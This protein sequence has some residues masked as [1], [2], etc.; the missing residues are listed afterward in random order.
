MGTERER[1][2][3][4]REELTACCNRESSGFCLLHAV[5]VAERSLLYGVGATV[6]RTVGGELSLSLG[7]VLSC[8]RSLRSRSV[9]RECIKSR[10]GEQTQSNLQSLRLFLLPRR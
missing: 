4:T 5:G 2:D 10:H 6:L 1:S 3:C 8:V 7:V 9:N